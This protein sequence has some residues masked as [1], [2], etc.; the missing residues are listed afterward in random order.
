MDLQLQRAQ[1]ENGRRHQNQYGEGAGGPANLALQDRPGGRD[2]GGNR[3]QGNVIPDGLAAG[4]D[5]LS[6]APDSMR[7][8]SGVPACGAD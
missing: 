4:Q 8:P 7:K 2:E 3:T 5:W 1:A 6:I